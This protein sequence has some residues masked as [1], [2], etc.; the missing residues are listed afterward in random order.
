MENKILKMENRINDLII[1]AEE[2]F[3]KFGIRDDLLNGKIYGGLDVLTELTGKKYSIT[4]K[5]LEI[6]E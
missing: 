6:K 5:G 1:Y 3:K 2:R 4:E